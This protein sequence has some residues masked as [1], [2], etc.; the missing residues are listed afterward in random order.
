MFSRRFFLTS[1]AAGGF[2]SS[3]TSGASRSEFH[4][5]EIEARIARRDFRGLTKEDLGTPAMILDQEIFEKNL[6][7]MAAHSKASGLQIRPHVKIH[8]CPEV[9]KRQVA[10]GGIGCSCATI[11]ESE[12]LAASGIR[13]VLWTCQ[14]AGI[15]K[16]SRAAALAR[17]DSTFHVVVDDPITAG[18]LEEAAGA[19]KTKM[20][21]VV[22]VYVGLTRQGIQPGEPALA[23]AQ[24]VASATNLRLAGLMGYSGAASHTNGWENRKKKSK[25]DLGPLMET[26]A[27]CRK[28]GLD[29]GLITGGSTGTYNIDK[30]IGLTELQCGSYVYMDT[31]YRHIGGKGDSEVYSDF[32]PALTVMTTVVSKTRP[33][34]ASID[35]GNKAMLRPTDEVKGRADVKIENQGAE[36]GMLL[37]TDSDREIRLGDRVE[38]YPSNLDMSVN[39]Y[40]R[41]YVARGESI[42]DVWPIMGRS[43]PPQR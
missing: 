10:L 32:G 16:I 29:V 28:S 13:G 1:S 25:D 41:I 42:V 9:T 21:V 40:D 4:Y 12:Y 33:N 22:D 6:R 18:K 19:N 27:L 2:L 30:E 23:L 3:V 34:Q 38:L 15:N 39:V 7:T 37:W 35:A 20:N 17:K 24:K 43:G 26:V 11:A 14:P 8:K 31:I 36:Y 5:S